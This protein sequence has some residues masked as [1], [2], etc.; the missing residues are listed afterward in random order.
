MLVRSWN[1]Y[2]GNTKPPRRRAFFDEMLRL[3]TADDP[4]VLCTQ[5]VP[6][7]KLARFTAGDLATRPKL[8]SAAL[9]DRITDLNHGVLRSAFS[10]QGNGILVA[11]RLRVLSHHRLILNPLRFRRAQARELKLGLA[12][13]LAWAKEG[14]NVQALRLADEQGRTYVVGNLHCTSYPGSSR[15]AEAELLRAAWF[16]TSTAVAG[17]VVVLAGDFNQ[18]VDS[19][20]LTALCSDEWGFSA[21]GPGIDHV[22]VR[23]AD[24]SPVRVWPEERRIWEGMLLSD[25]APVEVDV[26]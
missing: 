25:H 6:A 11:P 16:V 20:V 14:R 15:L 9:G 19:E 7:A 5:E 3:A 21:P 18:T 1:L 13:Q 17:D 23:G 2:H 4:D 24:A 8:L 26:L 12:A 22:L 10:G